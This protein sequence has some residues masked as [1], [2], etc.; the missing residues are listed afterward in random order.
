VAGGLNV[1]N[2]MA[3]T[4]PL[5]ALNYSIRQIS[6]LT[7]WNDPSAV[8]IQCTVKLLQ[9][10]PAAEFRRLG[11]LH[12]WV[13][14]QT[15]GEY[16]CY[17]FNNFP[18]TSVFG[19]FSPERVSSFQEEV[20]PGSYMGMVPSRYGAH[21]MFALSDNLVFGLGGGGSKN[22][23]A[24]TSMSVYARKPE[25][26]ILSKGTEIKSTMLMIRGRLL[27]E[28]LSS[29][30]FEEFRTRMGIGVPPAYKVLPAIGKVR[31]ICFSL[32]LD[33]QDYGFRGVIT[34]A[35]LPLRLPIR[36]YGLN[37]RWSAGVYNVRTKEWLPFGQVAGEGVAMTSL[38]TGKGDSDVFIGNPVQC[39][40]PEIALTFLVNGRDPKTKVPLAERDFDA[41]VDVHNPLDTPV[42]IT[43][44]RTPGF[45]LVAEFAKPLT[46]PAGSTVTVELK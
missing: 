22:P 4:A 12:C 32:S 45:E 43:L 37:E 25:G 3:P 46:V 2:Y 6:H 41:R 24:R 30:P 17:V 16:G 21:G 39:D 19:A 14:S 8:E 29:Q 13:P 27:T 9:D 42:D 34:R 33:T 26:D 11:L 36:V 23:A 5:S 15:G 44:R 7:R 1:W 40:R 20:R 28:E 38:E 18:L 10:I 35:V 31:N